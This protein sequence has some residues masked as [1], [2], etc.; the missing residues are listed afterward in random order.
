MKHD[1]GIGEPRFLSPVKN[2]LMGLL[3]RK[4]IANRGY[5]TKGGEPELIDALSV[6]P[7]KYKVVCNGA[8]QALYAAIDSLSGPDVGAIQTTSAPYWNYLTAISQR[9]CLRLNR[10]EHYYD[11][12][13]ILTLNTS[14]NNPDGIISDKE[15][16]I[17]DAAYAHGV[18]GFDDEKHNIKH[19]VSVWSASK[20]FGLSNARIG[21]LATDNI[22]IAKDAATYVE[23]TTSGVSGM[24]QQLLLN[25][26]VNLSKPRNAEETFH[27]YGDARSTLVSNAR[28]VFE[29]M[30][31]VIGKG[32][33]LLNGTK[34]FTMPNGMFAWVRAKDA[35]K[36]SEALRKAEIK[37]INGVNFGI[38]DKN[39]HRISLG[40]HKF[41][42]EEA[43]EDFSK[44][45]TT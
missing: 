4:D 13:S 22:Q 44:A 26:L 40:C 36:F 25:V 9:S 41:Q 29:A 5:P 6:F 7:G 45:L 20:L 37:T 16:D 11:K 18:Y 17:W 14:P 15:C 33:L 34:D 38:E 3:H 12:E 19:K 1:L 39:W 8:K 35:E 10:V 21:W 23:Q 30:K 2:F 42:M 31:D 24:S 27:L 28:L 32:N 43:M